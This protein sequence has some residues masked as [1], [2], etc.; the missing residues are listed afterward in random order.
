MKMKLKKEKYVVIEPWN[1]PFMFFFSESKVWQHFDW[2]NKSE[3]KMKLYNRYGVCVSYF[4]V[5]EA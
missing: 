4:K 3:N 1:G 5:I 2:P